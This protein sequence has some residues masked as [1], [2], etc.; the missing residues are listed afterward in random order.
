MLPAKRNGSGKKE[1]SL[2]PESKTIFGEIK[3][4]KGGLW[5]LGMAS[6]SRL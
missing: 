2:G 4:A 5:K 6:V 1:M 3:A